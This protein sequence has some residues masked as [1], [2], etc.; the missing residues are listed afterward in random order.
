M[1]RQELRA[2]YFATVQKYYGFY[3]DLL[4]RLHRLRASAGND[5]LALQASERA[6]ARLLLDMLVES[7]ADIRQGVDEKLLELN[8]KYHDKQLSLESQVQV[9]QEA[10]DSEQHA[11]EALRALEQAFGR[12]P[13]LLREGGSIPIANDFKRILGVDTLL[14]GLALPDDNPHSPNEKFNLESFR[15]GQRLGAYLW[16]ELGE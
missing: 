15:R 16:Q 8:T 2:S 5:G 4:M 14:V 3:I 1:R 13:V 12:P 10:A 11:L 6:R 7:H 9:L